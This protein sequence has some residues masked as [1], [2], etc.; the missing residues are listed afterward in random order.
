MLLS[1]AVYVVVTILIG[2]KQPT[3]VAPAFYYTLG[4]VAFVLAIAAVLVR[5]KMLEPADPTT[6]PD[7][8]SP[9]FLNRWLT[10]HIVSFAMAEAVAL[11]GF[12]LR[13]IG[14]TMHEVWPFFVAAALLMVLLTPRLPQS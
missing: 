3:P 1:I 9:A 12:V 8:T 4:M 5:N 10:A 7:P 2:P 11:I 13:F 6:T 14:K